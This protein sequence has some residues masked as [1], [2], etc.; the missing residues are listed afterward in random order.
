[1]PKELTATM[2]L[3]PGTIYRHPKTGGSYE[4]VGVSTCATN[5]QGGLCVVYRSRSSGIMFHRE[6][7]EFTDGRFVEDSPR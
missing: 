3:A 4:V 7:S 5:G 1:M 6:L 2:N